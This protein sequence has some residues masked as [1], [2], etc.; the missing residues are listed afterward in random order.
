[1]TAK[2]IIND[3]RDVVEEYILGLVRGTEHLARLDGWPVIVRASAKSP[4]RVAIVSGG[5]SGHEPAHAG[6]VG[7]GML[8][9]AVLGPVFTSPSVDAVY[10]AIRAVATDAGVLLVVKN[11]TGDR[12]NFGLAAEMARA[13]GIRVATLVVADDAALGDSSRAGRRGLTATVLVHKIAGAAADAGRSLDDIVALADR[14]LAGAATMGVALGPCSVPGAAAANFDLQGDEVEWGLGIHGEA[15]SERGTLATSR[16]IAETLV[17]R[18][19]DDLA[20]AEGEEVVA[21]VNSLGATPDLELRIL[22]G[23][24]LT[25][26]AERGI[27][28]R[29][30]WAGPFLTSLEMPGASVTL[31]RVD[32]ELLGLL[33]AEARVLAFPRATAPHDPQR[34][35]VVASPH[36]FA[37]RLGAASS[38][39]AAERVHAAVGAVARAVVAAEPELTGLDRRVGDGDLGLNLARGAEALL[40]ADLAAHAGAAEYLAAVSDI[41][42]REVGGTSG[43]LYSILLLSI[44]ERLSADAAGAEPSTSQWADAVAAGVARIRQVGGAAPGDSTMIDALQPAADALCTVG[45][46]DAAAAAARAGAEATAG[47]RPS[48]GRSSYLGDCAVGVP[49]PGAVAE[50]AAA[51]E[52]G[53]QPGCRLRA[54][55]RRGGRRVQVGGRAVGVPDPGAVAVAIM[56][57]TLA[58]AL[59]PVEG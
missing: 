20:L 17:G 16:Q 22:H 21:L 28:V 51:A 14:F 19:V 25:A 9:A 58:V 10:A 35:L 24:V 4:D 46:L 29:M 37:P 27:P 55:A 26:L 53:T 6:Y 54:R 23:D 43:P 13:D 1:M 34:E 49:D 7:S 40:T 59:A 39:G 32:H 56:L 50:A 42:R 31:A 8:D 15:G 3:P 52:R 2:K 38:D 41:V 18:V 36:A 57:E 30:T 5:G 44:A 47:L 48:L 12:L 45:H 33:G 11:Y